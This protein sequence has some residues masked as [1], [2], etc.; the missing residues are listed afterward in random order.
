MKILSYMTLWRRS[1]KFSTIELLKVLSNINI[2]SVMSVNCDL[3]IRKFAI[4]MKIC[5]NGCYLMKFDPFSPL[6]SP[7]QYIRILKITAKDRD[8]PFIVYKVD[9]LWFGKRLCVFEE[10]VKNR[11]FRWNLSDKRPL[12][13][14][15]NEGENQK[16]SKLINRNYILLIKSVKH[17]FTPI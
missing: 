5:Q 2:Q 12:C 15:V 16:L 7:D 13:P 17:V 4:C 8:G 14:L 1:R 11:D 6:Q 9:K 10:T 3:S